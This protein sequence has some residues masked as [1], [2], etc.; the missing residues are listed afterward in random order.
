MSP[1][2][3]LLSKAAALSELWYPSNGSEG[4]RGRLPI[5]PWRPVAAWKIITEIEHRN[6]SDTGDV[7][8]PGRGRLSVAN[9]YVEKDGVEALPSEPPQRIGETADLNHF[10]RSHEGGD[11]SHEPGQL[12]K[13]LA[14]QKKTKGRLI[15]F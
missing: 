7:S 5:R 10:D 14:Y 13:P 8:T 6:R 2:G 1:Q 3:W 9:A 12:S 11:R 4:R 15:V